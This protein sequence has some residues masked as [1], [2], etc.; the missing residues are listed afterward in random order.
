M[1][2]KGMMFA[3]TAVAATTAY[4]FLDL[5]GI[6]PPFSDTWLL[7]P[8]LVFGLYISLEWLVKLR[9]HLDRLDTTIL[10]AI[11]LLSSGGVLFQFTRLISPY[12]GEDPRVGVIIFIAIA[13]WSLLGLLLVPKQRRAD[14]GGVLR[15]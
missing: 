8:V 10:F 9:V 3:V 1:F 4:F 7:V 6:K 2:L 14:A 13:G 15:R 11:L 5:I 12:P